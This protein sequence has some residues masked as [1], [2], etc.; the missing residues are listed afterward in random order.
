M[1]ICDKNNIILIMQYSYIKDFKNNI[2]TIFLYRTFHVRVLGVIVEFLHF[3][4]EDVSSLI[5]NFVFHRYV[6][7]AIGS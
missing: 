7:I 1:N 4:M 2:Y 3:V 5:M 6:C